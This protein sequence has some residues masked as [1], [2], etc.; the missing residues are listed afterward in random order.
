[1][2]NECLFHLYVFK[3]DLHMLNYLMIK[4]K[5]IFKCFI[6]FWK[7]LG[8]SLMFWKFFQ[9][10]KSVLL[11]NSCI[12]IFAS[13]VSRTQVAKMRKWIS[14]SSKILH[15]ESLNSLASHSREMA[16]C[17]SC[18][19]HLRR[20]ARNSQVP[21]DYLSRKMS[22]FSVFKEAHNDSFSKTLF[23]LP[24]VSLNPKHPFHSN[25][26]QNSLDFIPKTSKVCFNTFYL[27]IP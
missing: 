6:C 15:R 24:R 14:I 10:A 11:K 13:K 20:F 16:S 7:C 4:P 5:K 2:F 19:V 27:I 3:C 17:E 12:S 18:P 23:C 26:N 25:L 9:K 8:V 1:M 22:G 21:R